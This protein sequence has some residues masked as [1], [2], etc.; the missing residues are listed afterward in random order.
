MRCC[1]PSTHWAMPRDSVINAF[2]YQWSVPANV[3]VPTKFNFSNG[4]SWNADGAAMNRN[5][6]HYKIDMKDVQ[7]FL[8][9]FAHSDTLD[10][11][12]TKGTEPTWKANLSSTSQATSDLLACTNKLLGKGSGSTQPNSY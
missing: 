7:K 9:D 4:S 3:A 5:S 6:V 8:N 12:F 11:V 10:I 1:W 2:R